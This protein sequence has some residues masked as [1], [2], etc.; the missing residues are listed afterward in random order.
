MGKNI[1]HYHTTIAFDALL[2]GGKLLPIYALFFNPSAPLP[3]CPDSHNLIPSSC[4]LA[5]DVLGDLGVRQ[6]MRSIPKNTRL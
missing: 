5:E 6:A 4:Y 1:E 3:Q 2:G